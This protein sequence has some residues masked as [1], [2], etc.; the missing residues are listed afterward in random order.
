[1]NQNSI[2]VVKYENVILKLWRTCVEASSGIY[3]L[4]FIHIFTVP[5]GEALRGYRSC[6]CVILYLK[7]S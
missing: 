4:G 7:N 1:M 3:I 6:M 2:K 5:L